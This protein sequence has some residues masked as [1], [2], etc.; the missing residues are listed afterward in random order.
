MTFVMGRVRFC[1]FILSDF[2]GLRRHLRVV[3]P[4]FASN[5]PVA[6]RPTKR[7]TEPLF[8]LKNNNTLPAARQEIVD[9]F[10]SSA[11][12]PIIEISGPRLAKSARDR[13]A[14]GFERLL[15]APPS[16]RLVVVLVPFRFGRTL[17]RFR[18]C[19]LAVRVHKLARVFVDHCRFHKQASSTETHFRAP[20]TNILPEARLFPRKANN[21]G[22]SASR[23]RRRAG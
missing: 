21:D 6:R 17:S 8:F 14:H 5:R 19:P 10:L 13:P 1:E 4:S 9:N 20:G 12:Y 2:K 22:A 7:T 3:S 11:G 15:D 23:G 18:N 16:L